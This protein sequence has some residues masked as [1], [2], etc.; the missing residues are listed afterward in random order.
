MCHQANL[1]D[2]QHLR[3]RSQLSKSLHHQPPASGTRLLCTVGHRS[4]P[5]Q[6]ELEVW[7]L[8]L[9]ADLVEE[10]VPVALGALHH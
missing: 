4:D 10:L 1:W 2:T 5:C 7:A 8:E 9:V 6:L 3:N